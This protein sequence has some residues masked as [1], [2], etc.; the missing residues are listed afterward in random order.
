[1]IADIFD[2]I[3]GRILHV[4]YF[5]YYVLITAL[6]PFP[7]TFVLHKTRIRII[8]SSLISM[9]TQF[10][11]LPKYPVLSTHTLNFLFGPITLQQ[12]EHFSSPKAHVL[13]KL[14]GKLRIYMWTIICHKN[15]KYKQIY[16]NKEPTLSTLNIF[17]YFR[18]L[19]KIY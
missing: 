2:E 19:Q 12:Q 5:W 18:H 1:M 7:V 8:E 4:F 3:G 6:F 16:I 10:A 17:V 9:M 11:S 14:P 15:C 13:K